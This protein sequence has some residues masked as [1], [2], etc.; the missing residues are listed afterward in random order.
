V[1]TVQTIAWYWPVAGGALI[2]L[3]AGGYLIL[4][5]RI[6]GISG[7][8]A[9]ATG[10]ARNT[11]RGLAAWFLIGLLGGSAIA[12]RLRGMPDLQVTGAWPVLVIGGLLVGYGTRL[13][14]GCTS[15]HGICGIARLS[16]RSLVATGVFMAFGVGTV[17]VVRHLIG[18]AP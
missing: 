12:M 4:L 3:A 18:G 8:V 13:G 17:W 1:S 14:S 7:L 5:G 16:P 15:G 9:A 6:A 2:G 10:L 11:A